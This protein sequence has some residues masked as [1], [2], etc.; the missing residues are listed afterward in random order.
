MPPLPTIPG[1]E[2]LEPLGGGPL[3]EVYAGREQHTDAP[4]AVKLVRPDWR[5]QQT[6]VKLLQREARAGLAVRHA[7]LVRITTVHVT[8]PPWFLVMEWLPGETLRNR[9]Q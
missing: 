3:T 1:Y 2:L 9:L 7:N 8:R 5:E 4:C 6:A